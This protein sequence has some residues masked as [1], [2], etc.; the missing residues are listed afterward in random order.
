MGLIQ[1]NIRVRVNNFNEDYFRSIGY[2]VPRNTYINIKINELPIGSGLKI[3]VKCDYCGKEFDKAYRRY[4]ET[5]DDICC[6]ECKTYKMQNTDLKKYG[7]KCSL[8]NK[9]IQKKSQETN[10][11][12]L[13]VKYP[14]QSQEILQKC[15]D[16]T[17]EKY[18]V[19]NV[20]QSPEIRKTINKK[21]LVKGI[22]TSKQ[23]IY[24]HKLYGGILNYYIDRCYI[25]IYLDKYNICCEYNG[26]GHNLSVI[27]NHITQEAF[28]N[29]EKERDSRLINQGYKI[30]KII[31]IK[32]KLP[33]DKELLNIKKCAI[34]N[35]NI[36][37]IYIYD[38][39]NK[40]EKSFKV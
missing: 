30:F 25:D 17:L 24:I 2:D 34:K 11:K 33:S 5:K 22:S 1:E 28:D 7:N 29:R 14:F 6:D 23:Q 35:L 3:K 27:H 18:G 21:Y 13:G 38:I 19:E 31:S 39:D 16:T 4:L 8:R 36:N 15:K 10:L 12:K 37:D 32:D 26:G 40:S 9:D 20:L